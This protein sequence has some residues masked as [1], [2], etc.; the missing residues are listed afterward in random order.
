MMIQSVSKVLSV[1]TGSVY[2]V[3]Q[4]ISNRQVFA[5]IFRIIYQQHPIT[6]IKQLCTS[7]K[8]Q[9]HEPKLLQMVM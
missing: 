4:W 7:R 8:M 6:K 2:V 1:N 3:K 9:Y 5:N